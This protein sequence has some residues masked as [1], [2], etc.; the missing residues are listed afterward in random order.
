MVMMVV[1]VVVDFCSHA[2]RKKHN[3][4]Y[5]IVENRVKNV[6]HFRNRI[7]NRS[8][9]INQRVYEILQ[10]LS[11]TNPSRQR[12]VD[13]ALVDANWVGR[14]AND[15]WS[16]V[17]AADRQAVEM[18]CRSRRTIS[19][20]FFSVSI[21]QSP[22]N[23][24]NFLCH[25]LSDCRA[26]HCVFISRRLLE[27]LLQDLLFLIFEFSWSIRLKPQRDLS[28]P[29]ENWLT[30]THWVMKCQYRWNGVTRN[31]GQNNRLLFPGD[32]FFAFR[33]M[34]KAHKW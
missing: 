2:I 22:K 13:D 15:P 21:D 27:V 4:F 23:C 9:T 6:F 33:T 8:T 29:Q 32:F 19:Y 7:W 14:L 10:R 25:R 5:V 28:N 16:G 1:V 17:Y 30:V 18:T 20:R 31:F 3:I 24:E 26:P 34:S 11:A 12:R